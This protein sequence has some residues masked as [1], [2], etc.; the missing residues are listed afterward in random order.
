MRAYLITFRPQSNEQ[1]L[2]DVF[3]TYFQDFISQYPHR[4][5]I[6][7]DDSPD[8]HYHVFV[9]TEFRDKE[10]LYKNSQYKKSISQIRNII[11]D[12]YQTKWQVAMDVT[13]VK[14]TPEDLRKTLG[15]VCKD[16]VKRGGIHQISNERC[17]DGCKY[18]WMDQKVEA[19][20]Y[21]KNNWT[22]VTT[23]NAHSLI[24]DFCA[25]NEI[26]LETQSYVK[27]KMMMVEQRY[28]FCQISEK[29]QQSIFAE[30]AYHHKN[31]A[32]KYKAEQLLKS[33]ANIP[34]SVLYSWQCCPTCEAMND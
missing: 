34:D 6:E 20:K 2:L 17:A 22:A 19:M 3:I 11:Q 12:G 8:A 21:K 14:D 10:K 27:V 15:Y 26:S 16:I 5:C 9:E 29:A 30:L 1:D 25:K 13:I 24:E 33:E 18:Y 4:W 32:F 28:T 23:K 7:K 31:E